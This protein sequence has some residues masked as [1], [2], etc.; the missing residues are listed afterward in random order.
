MLH[1]LRFTCK[2]L[3]TSILLGGFFTAQGAEMAG[4]SLLN[5]FDPSGFSPGRKIA[6]GVFEVGGAGVGS[7]AGPLEKPR[8]LLL[9]RFQR[10]FKKRN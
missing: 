5:I 2:L 8:E 6:I 1:P 10:D 9:E 3:L 7:N 4:C